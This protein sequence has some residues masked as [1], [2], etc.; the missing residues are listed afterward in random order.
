MPNGRKSGADVIIISEVS[1]VIRITDGLIQGKIV[2]VKVA[3]AMPLV[4]DQPEDNLDN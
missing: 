4:I 2:N 1:F 3:E